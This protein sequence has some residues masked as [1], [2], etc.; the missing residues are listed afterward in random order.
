[1]VRRFATASLSL[2]QLQLYIDLPGA[3]AASRSHMTAEAVSLLHLVKQEDTKKQVRVYIESG[4]ADSRAFCLTDLKQALDPAQGLASLINVSLIAWGNAYHN[5]V[6]ECSEHTSSTYNRNGSHCWQHA[7][8][9]GTKSAKCFTRGATTV[10][11]HGA[12][13]GEVDK[14]IN[15]AMTHA[16]SPWPY[17]QCLLSR[18]H[19]NETR[20][21]ETT[22]EAVASVCESNVADS[23]ERQEITDCA[24]SDEGKTLLIQAAESTPKH[25]GV[26]YVTIDNHEVDPDKFFEE[27]CKGLSQAQVPPAC[28]SAAAKAA[29]AAAKAA[30]SSIASAQAAGAQSL[31]TPA[32]STSGSTTLVGYVDGQPYFGPYHTMSDG[33]K[34]TGES[35]SASSKVITSTVAPAV[36]P[37]M[38]PAAAA[39][40]AGLPAAPQRDDNFFTDVK[41]AMAEIAKDGSLRHN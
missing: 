40:K 7:C 38:A 15:C 14:R 35:H 34:M 36:A 6:D 9:N 27:L 13:E 41:A 28:A 10:H 23:A 12:K 18:Y 3:T 19:E 21:H 39:P 1:M 24:T 25:R 32:S 31:A 4:C 29:S 20:T 5:G 22:A 37:A 16:G 33:Q 26:P 8:M 17:V 30:A 11:Q 2:L